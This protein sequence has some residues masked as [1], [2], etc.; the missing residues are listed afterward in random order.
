MSATNNI[1]ANLSGDGVEYRYADSG[2][3]FRF[4]LDDDRRRIVRL[5]R[6]HE[7]QF[8]NPYKEIEYE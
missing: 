2:P 6:C 5:G 7:T 4:L 1:K 3:Q 8:G